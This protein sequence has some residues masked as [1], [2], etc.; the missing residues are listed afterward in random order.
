MTV[1]QLLCELDGFS[2]ADNV[3]VIGATNFSETLDPALVRPGRFDREIHLP[4]PDV[5]G[6]KEIIDHYL[7]KFT[8]IGVDVK[9]EV[10]ARGTPGCSGADLFNILN[11][12]A[13]EAS[14]SNSPVMKMEHVEKAKDKVL[15]GAERKSY[16]LPFNKELTSLH[17][18]SLS[19]PTSFDLVC[20]N[21]VV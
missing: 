12:A 16:K 20:S 5:A 14:K 17:F 19:L 3:I 18:P 10:L 4:L 1:N 6:R 15:M 7:Q 9:S 21:F 2:S 13:V 8:G 11:H